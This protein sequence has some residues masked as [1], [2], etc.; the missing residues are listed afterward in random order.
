M[1]LSTIKEELESAKWNLSQ[2]LKELA[3]YDGYNE[4]GKQYVVMSARRE[5]E[6][7]FQRIH[8]AMLI[9]DGKEVQVPR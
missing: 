8:R 4:S 5:L 2:A 7:V 3:K 6:I 9:D 1:T